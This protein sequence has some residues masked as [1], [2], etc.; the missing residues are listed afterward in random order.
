MIDTSERCT[1]S[2]W[3]TIAHP[4]FTQQPKCKSCLG[5][6]TLEIFPLKCKCQASHDVCL[7]HVHLPARRRKPRA[8][9]DQR[10]CPSLDEMVFRHRHCD[11]GKSELRPS[12][13]SFNVV[14]RVGSG[15][16]SC[17]CNSLALTILTIRGLPFWH[18][19]LGRP[20]SLPP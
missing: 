8:A 18:T 20:R 11:E 19:S 10:Q 16:K 5:H 13:A 7:I 12:L 14:R 2:S 17:G 15:L 1:T 4:R 3:A 6:H 9:H